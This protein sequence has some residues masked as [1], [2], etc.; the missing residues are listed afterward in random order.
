MNLYVDTYEFF[1]AYKCIKYEQLG[2]ERI[3]CLQVY[4]YLFTCCCYLR[5]HKKS[6]LHVR[7]GPFT[8]L[9]K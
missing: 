2:V 8:I 1:R 6:L 7:I 9:H 4:T 5:L 3:C